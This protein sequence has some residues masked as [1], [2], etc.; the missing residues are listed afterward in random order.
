[1]H[2]TCG[3]L[4]DLPINSYTAPFQAVHLRLQRTLLVL[5]HCFGT[6]AW[7]PQ[8]ESSSKD[9]DAILKDMLNGRVDTV[10]FSGVCA[11]NMAGCGAM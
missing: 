6:C 3:R 2:A 7:A 8:V 9:I 5:T 4:V 1:M 11:H 10:E